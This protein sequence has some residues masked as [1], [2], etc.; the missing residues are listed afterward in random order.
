MALD[1]LKPLHNFFLFEFLN[2]TRNGLFIQ[3]NKGRIILRN[4]DLDVQGKY[5]RWARVLAVGCDVK[6]FKVDDIVVIE[7]G[8]W[9]TGMV[10]NDIKFWMSDETAVAGVGGPELE[11]AFYDYRYE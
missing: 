6:E 1:N 7:P 11:E 8:R 9:T 2:E 3:K 10:W 5:V 4:P